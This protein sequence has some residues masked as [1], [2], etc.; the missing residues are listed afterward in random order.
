MNVPHQAEHLKPFSFGLNIN[1]ILE[2]CPSNVE[3]AYVMWLYIFVY[4]CQKLLYLKDIPVKLI[5]VSHSRDL[6][7]LLIVLMLNFSSFVQNVTYKNNLLMAWFCFVFLQ[8]EVMGYC[9]HEWKNSKEEQFPSLSFP[10]HFPLKLTLPYIS[11]SPA[12]VPT[13]QKNTWGKGFR[14][15]KHKQGTRVAPPPIP[16]TADKVGRLA[17]VSCVTS[18]P[19]WIL[20]Q[21]SFLSYGLVNN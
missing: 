1:N 14:L 13:M 6:K 17:Q 20:C 15:K 5:T 7:Y 3:Y 12:G 21:F 9:W 8:R 4:W 11:I 18:S 10:A 2:S 19:W 16:I